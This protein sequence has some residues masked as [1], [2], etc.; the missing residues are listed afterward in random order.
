MGDSKAPA[1]TPANLSEKQ[2]RE[3]AQKQTNPD[4][5]KKAEEEEAK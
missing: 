5:K 3:L 2:R 1:S 4:A